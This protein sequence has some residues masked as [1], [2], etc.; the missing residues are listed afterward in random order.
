MIKLYS[1]GP[2]FG[3]PDASPFVLKTMALLKF[4]GLRYSEDHSGYGRAPKGKLPY[5]DDEG[6]IIADSTFI[7]LY[8]EKTYGM[9]FDAGLT[10]EQRA[11]GWAVEKMLEEHYYWLMV[12][13]RWIDDGNF[14]RGPAKFFARVPAL[15]RPLIKALIRKKIARCLTAQGLGR[16][17]NEELAELARRDVDA[18]SILLGDKPYL[19]GAA[20]SAAD[21]TAFA[22]VAESLVPELESPLRDAVASKPNL[23]AYRDRLL[24]AYFPNYVAA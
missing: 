7:R 4:A 5:I 17:S 14:E 16:H 13:A 24:A 2:Y 10:P 20:P 21:A 15:V 6:K 23:V 11:A 9:D 3:L 18:L 12:Q 19:F 22:M 8:L 1:F